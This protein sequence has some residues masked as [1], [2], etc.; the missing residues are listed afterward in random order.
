MS[1][2]MTHGQGSSAIPGFPML[3]LIAAL[4]IWYIWAVRKVNREHPLLPW[5]KRF[6][7]CFGIGIVLMAMVTVGPVAAGAMERF[8]V[9]MVQHIVLMMLSTPFLILGAPVLLA[10]RSSSSVGR[11]RIRRVITSRVFEFLTNPV[12]SWIVFAAV[13]V[14]MHFTPAME[15]F[16][17]LGPAGHTAEQ[18]LYIAAA[19]AFYYTVLPGNP[20]RNRARPALRAISLFLMMIPETMTGFFL[21]SASLPSVPTFVHAAEL[22]HQDPLLDQRFGGALM[23]SGA[24]IIDV[25]WIALA[26]YEWFDSEASRTRRLDAKLRAESTVLP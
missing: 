9:H 10:L 21:Y 5:P 26:V 12:V 1:D 13:L 16:M 22:A 11:R 4:A 23:W 25:A 2:S 3:M 14:S 24:M 17:A 18:L 6:S 8:S 15:W 7:W 20:A 19:A